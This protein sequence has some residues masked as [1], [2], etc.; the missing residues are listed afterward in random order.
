MTGGERLGLKKK[1]VWKRTCFDVAALQR[2]S[3][4]WGE[5]P[6]HCIDSC[7]N[8][9]IPHPPRFLLHFFF[10]PL[11]SFDIYT[12]FSVRCEKRGLGS[13]LRLST[14]YSGQVPLVMLYNSSSPV[15]LKTSVEQ[16]GFRHARIIMQHRMRHISIFYF[17]LFFSRSRY[18]G[19]L[20]SEVKVTQ[21]ASLINNLSACLPAGSPDV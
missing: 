15:L 11:Q 2:Y 17:I 8:D 12:S 10:I 16:G 6:L 1:W 18:F 14:C 19:T 9:S 4:L 7:S 20:Y 13:D 3:R 5:R 21:K